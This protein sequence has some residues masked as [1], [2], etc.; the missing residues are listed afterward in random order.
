M[1]HFAP[2]TVSQ[3]SNSIPSTMMA[4]SGMLRMQGAECD[5][6]EVIGAMSIKPT[7]RVLLKWRMAVAR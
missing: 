2:T 4:A 3:S 1:I 6:A 7:M 5:H